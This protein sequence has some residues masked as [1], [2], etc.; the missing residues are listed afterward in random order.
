MTSNRYSAF[1]LAP[2]KR[3]LRKMRAFYLLARRPMARHF[4]EV[5][6]YSWPPS[7]FTE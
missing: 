4:W 3:I 1:G 6:R 5:S 2:F 7:G